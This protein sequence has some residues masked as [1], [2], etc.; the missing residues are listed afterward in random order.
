MNLRLIGAWVVG[1]GSCLGVSMAQVPALT[2]RD[3]GMYAGT[4]WGSPTAAPPPGSTEERTD[5]L[6][7]TIRSIW[8]NAGSPNPDLSNIIDEVNNGWSYAPKRTMLV[9]VQFWDGEDRYQ[10]P[11]L[12][13]DV[14]LQRILQSVQNLSPVLDK[15]QGITLSEEN[16]PVGGRTQL[17]QY[18]YDGVKAQYPNLPVYQ[19]WTPNTAH[20]KQF[21]GTWLK[22]DG[23]VFDPYTLT[24][25][26]PAYQ[27]LWKPDPYLRLV[28]KYVVTGLPLVAIAP[29]TAETAFRPYYDPS[30][31]PFTGGTTLWDVMDHQT[32]INTAFN[33][34]T[35]FY[36]SNQNGSVYFPINTSDPLMNQLNSYVR[37]FAATERNL[38]ANYTGDASIADVWSNGPQ[39]VVNVL[40]QGGKNIVFEDKFRESDFLE[41]SV[42]TGLRDLIIDGEDLRTRGFDGRNANAAMIYHFQGGQTLT[43]PL[44][45]LKADVNAA[46]GGE[47]KISVSTD[48]THWVQSAQTSAGGKQLLELSTQNLPSFAG[49]Q[50]LYVKLEL[51]GHTGT[52]NIPAV[53]VDD[54]RVLQN[55]PTMRGMLLNV[56]FDTNYTPGTL[57]GQWGGI[58]GGTWDAPTN[59][60]NFEVVA[61][62]AGT[63][64][65]AARLSRTAGGGQATIPLES[66]LD[67]SAS[68]IIFSFD[69]MKPNDATR[70]LITLWNSASGNNTGFGIELRNGP[71][72]PLW[73][74][75]DSVYTAGESA[76]IASGFVPA[77]GVWYHVEFKVDGSGKTYDLYIGQQG[78]EQRSLIAENV[79][80]RA[81]NKLVD[82]FLYL[83]QGL[84]ESVVYLDN[85]MV[86][87]GLTAVPEP[88]MGLLGG[89]VLPLI[90]YWKHR[91]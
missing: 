66:V 30:S 42:G 49:V 40:P 2:A 46:L 78:S 15:I 91:R 31:T 22:A 14:Y 21:E 64:G 75:T 5:V 11:M 79:V 57:H 58:N 13:K 32:A 37:N 41:Q 59:L 44:V 80:W 47:A 39:T 52:F 35:S 84:G 7:F 45:A 72:E 69:F 61:S 71:G 56:N 67:T 70:G 36:W 29:A 27:D 1:M 74:L 12:D 4:A 87:N 86:T 17:L 63:N 26:N 25:A 51:T 68:D 85:L 89:I 16:V 43:Y 73:Y 53:R 90:F 54:L 10:G 6:S 34:P 20:P 33:I 88:A 83:P 55:T 24:Q 9:R 81:P 76:N 8:N 18:L 77:N 38:P 62:G 50:D 48:G 23:W 60:G 28:Q 82:G 65:N 3:T 19:W